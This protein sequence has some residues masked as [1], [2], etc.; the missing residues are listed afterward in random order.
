MPDT[1]AGDQQILATLQSVFGFDSFRPLQREIIEATLSGS[2]IIALMP[3]GGGKSLCYQL[4]AL[5]SPGLTVVVSPLIALMKD[6]V[7]KLQAM[8]VAADFINSSLAPAEAARRQAGIARGALKLLYVAPE[9]LM[10]PG[11][12]RL[13]MSVQPAA[14]AIDE[15]HCISEWG[16]DFRP[17]YR[18]LT[19]LRDLFPSTSVAAFTATATPRVQEDIVQQLRLREPARFRGSFDRPNL[20]YRVLP[21]REPYKQLLNYIRTRTGQSGIVYC[22]ARATTEAIAARLQADGIRAA[23]YHAG[24]NAED[25]GKVQEA[26]VRD[27]IDIVVATIAFGMG[28]DKPDVRFVVHYDLPRNLEGYYQESGR[29][30]RDGDPS[31]CILLYSYGDAIKQEYFI[32][33]RSIERE[34]RNGHEQLQHMLNWAGAGVCRRRELLRYFDEDLAAAHERCCDVCEPAGELVDVTEASRQLLE[35]VQ[36]LRGGFGIAYV[37][38]VLRGSRDERILRA[39]HDRLQIY[40]AGQARDRQYWRAV[41]EELLRAGYL[42][43][44]AEEFHVVR[45]TQRGSRA[46]VDRESILLP[47]ATGAEAGKR[48]SARDAPDPMFEQ[49]RTLRKQLA[50][51]LG[52]PPYVIF[53]DTTL[54]QMSED[55]PTTLQLLRRIPGVGERKLQDYGMA[56]LEV[57]QGSGTT[58]SEA[59]PPPRL[60]TAHVGLSDSAEATLALFRTGLGPQEIAAQRRLSGSTVSEQLARAIDLGEDVDLDR[61]VAAD[62]R[63]AITRAIEEVGPEL[64]RPIRDRLGESFSY[65]EIRYMRSAWLRDER[66][67]SS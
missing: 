26:F 47:L 59:P 23:A 4:P 66:A 32:N 30:G 20:F 62:R 16:H 19:R 14:F 45:L 43:V 50:G 35:C 42:L 25:R 8:G 31:D 27:D 24:L 53:H 7:D 38:R 6:Q 48:D 29:A 49:L 18:E 33:Q 61:L 44:A 17:E 46:L 55:R 63:R 52:V 3:T 2:D 54:R 12:M 58:R 65:D 34:R 51:D 37:I 10:M 36:Q 41:F 56:F 40:G 13:I 21:K 9:R 60:V 67:E 22:H 11:F 39:G 28:I 15:A 64:L 57:I 5:V 1:E